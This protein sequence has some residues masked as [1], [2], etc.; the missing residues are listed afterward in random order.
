MTHEPYEELKDGEW[1][2]SNWDE[3]VLE[4]V[5]A[6]EYI[7][8]DGFEIELIMHER[9]FDDKDFPN[10]YS[11]ALMINTYSPFNSLV[12]SQ[13]MELSTGEEAQALLNFAQKCFDVQNKY[14]K[15]WEEK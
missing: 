12:T 11:Y 9:C 14:N 5:V 2:I 6:R 3:E 10:S 15:A 13:E 8:G 7:K 4:R 1:Y